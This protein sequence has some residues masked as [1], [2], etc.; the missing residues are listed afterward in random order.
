VIQSKTCPGP[1][2]RNHR[3]WGW[4]IRWTFSLGSHSGFNK[5]QHVSAAKE[6]SFPQIIGVHRN[7]L[8]FSHSLLCTWLDICSTQST[9]MP[10][11]SMDAS[12][13]DARAHVARCLGGHTLRQ[14]PSVSSS[15]PGGFGPPRL[16][17]E[18]LVVCVRS[19]DRRC[20]SSSCAS[21]T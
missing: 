8:L 9:P 11:P 12:S 17:G 20:S 10:S 16:A 13:Y 3:G 5:K 2:P 4:Q 7:D 14:G 6:M 19:Y 1:C 18:L 15:F 21:H